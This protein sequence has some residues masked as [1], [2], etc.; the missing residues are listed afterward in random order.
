MEL[1]K[2]VSVGIYNTD[3]AVKRGT[4]TKKRKTAMFELDR[5]S[6]NP[7]SMFSNVSK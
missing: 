6:S 5:L 4:Q 2:I 7:G 3:L 1:A